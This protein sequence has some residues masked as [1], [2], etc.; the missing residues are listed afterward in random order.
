MA[1]ILIIIGI[2]LFLP[3]LSRCQDASSNAPRIACDQPVCD[4]GNADN[5]KV[6]KHTYI[7]RNDGS[8]S[9]VISN[10]HACCGATVL[11]GQKIIAPGTNTTLEVN[12]SLLGRK[13]RV[14][15]SLY[16]HSNDRLCPIFQLRMI[17]A[18]IAVEST[19]IVTEA[20]AVKPPSITSLKA[21]K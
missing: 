6:I 18:G 13:G 5:H 12:L 19:N 15:K 21:E 8:D 11:L 20:E 14:N 16:V 9:L 4:F 3:V 7:L 17:G 2:A 1:K 10:I